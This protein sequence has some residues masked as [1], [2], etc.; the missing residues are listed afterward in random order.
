MSDVHCSK[1]LKNDSLGKDE[2]YIIISDTMEP[3]MEFGEAIRASTIASSNFKKAYDFALIQ[4]G[5]HEPQLGYK[6]ALNRVT[7]EF[8]VQIDDKSGQNKVTIARV[9]KL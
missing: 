7:N 6:A 2:I 1:K 8:A 5:I 4:G 3:T 9:K